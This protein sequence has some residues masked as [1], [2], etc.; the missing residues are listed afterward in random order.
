MET[1]VKTEWAPCVNKVLLYFTLTTLSRVLLSHAKNA[2][3]IALPIDP[4]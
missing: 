4:S 2:Y 1:S 3:F